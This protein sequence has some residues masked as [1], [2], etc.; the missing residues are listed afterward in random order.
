M[1]LE[2][3]AVSCACVISTSLFLVSILLLA[4]GSQNMQ[5][6]HVL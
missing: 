3:F 4:A 1:F 2:D 6:W 5:L